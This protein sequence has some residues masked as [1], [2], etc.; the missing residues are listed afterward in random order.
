MPVRVNG[1][2]CRGFRYEK[3]NKYTNTYI[4]YLVYNVN[5]N[6]YLFIYIMFISYTQNMF[7]LKIFARVF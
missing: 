1:W 4:Y 6:I 3:R 2:K 5:F 7:T